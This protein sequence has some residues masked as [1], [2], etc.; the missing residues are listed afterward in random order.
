[1][2]LKADII[3]DK[4]KKITMPK[5]L[6]WILGI[7]ATLALLLVLAFLIFSESLP[8]G[9]TINK[10]AW[11][12]TG[13]IQWSFPRGHDFIWDKKRHLAEVKWEQRSNRR[14]RRET[15]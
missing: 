3:I 12:N 6:K 4:Q 11:D 14:S 13:I 10:P 5:W 7:F 2:I 8:K 15:G 9:Q 1:M